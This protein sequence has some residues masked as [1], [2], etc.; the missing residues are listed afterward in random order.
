VISLADQMAA[1]YGRL[2]AAGIQPIVKGTGQTGG[3]LI[4]GDATVPAYYEIRQLQVD[5]VPDVLRSR[6]FQNTTR[7]EVRSVTD[8]TPTPS[9]NGALTGSTTES[10]A[11]GSAIGAAVDL[12]RF[13]NLEPV[14]GVL[15][16]FVA[17]GL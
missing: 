6:R 1:H 9:G 8:L 12:L 15:D 14:A 4:G 3:G 7:R 17:P 13:V 5:N 16:A 2:T 11:G 10:A